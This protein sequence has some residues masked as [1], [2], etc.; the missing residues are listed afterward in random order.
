MCVCVCV[1]LPQFAYKIQV[2]CK[3][4][5]LIE[6]HLRPADM[7]IITGICRNVLAYFG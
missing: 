4:K 7:N 6:M 2:F 5:I 3:N 1:L